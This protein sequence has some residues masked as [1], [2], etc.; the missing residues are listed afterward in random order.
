[1]QE[2]YIKSLEN[3]ENQSYI[4]TF[5]SFTGLNLTSIPI[6]FNLTLNGIPF[7]SYLN[8]TKR[9]D[10]CFFLKDKKFGL[11][12]CFVKIENQIFVIY[13]QLV[14]VYSPFYSILCPE[15]RAR[16]SIC[17]HTDQFKVVDI[18]EIK[19]ATLIKFSESDIYV[20]DFSM[21][22]LFN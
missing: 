10:S 18:R 8:N 1:M 11:I 3:T 9:C 16:S 21:S 6:C 4:I 2:V 7:S 15:L 5:N 20:S 14:S 19:K 22:H 17:Y 13:K 12:E